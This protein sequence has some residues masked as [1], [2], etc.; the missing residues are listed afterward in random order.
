MNSKPVIKPYP[1]RAFV[2]ILGHDLYAVEPLWK[3]LF[4]RRSDILNRRG[5]SA[6]AL[7]DVYIEPY[8]ESFTVGDE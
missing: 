6:F 8:K 7:V 1:A 4:A 3:K 5:G 2:G